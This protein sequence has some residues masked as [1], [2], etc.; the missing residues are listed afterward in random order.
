MGQQHKIESRAGEGVQSIDLSNNFKKGCSQ[1]KGW[2]YI[3]SN[4]AMPGLVKVGF[5]LKDPELRAAELNCTGAPHPY[6][7]DYEVLVDEPREIEQKVHK[8]LSAKREGKEWFRTT[9]EEAGAAIKSVVGSNIQLEN[10]KNVDRAKSERIAGKRQETEKNRIVEKER[11]RQRVSELEEERRKLQE[12]H[13]LQIDTLPTSTNFWGVYFLAFLAI[14]VGLEVMMNGGGG[15][16]SGL[17][18]FAAFLAFIPTP[19][20]TGYFKNK[21]KEK[22]A[23]KDLISRQ[24][25]E[26]VAINDKIDSQRN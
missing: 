16:G 22:P 18:I 23:Y 26:L 7:V 4:K 3:I 6:V 10:H 17:Y 8:V 15:G 1:M 12:R 19:I 9:T 13:K 2:V 14:V 25:Q 5:T 21:E 24:R 11:K 20:V